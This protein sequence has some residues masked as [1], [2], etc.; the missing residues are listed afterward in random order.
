M[1]GLFT[2]FLLATIF[3]TACSGAA[4]ILPTPSP[5]PDSETPVASPP[6]Q[7][8]DDT[9]PDYAPQPGDQAL[10]RSSA[11]VDSVDI[12]L[13][14]SYPIQ[15]MLHISGHLPTP[16]HELRVTT[17]APDG[18]NYINVTVYSVVDAQMECVQVLRAFDANV[19]LGSFPPG[20]YTIVVNGEMIGEFDS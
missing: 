2:T 3:L 7:P 17:A 11:F 8:P 6:G 4:D 12:L 20:H 5:P 1:K 10:K 19:S 18:Q 9:L 16:C 13:M 15:I 14:E